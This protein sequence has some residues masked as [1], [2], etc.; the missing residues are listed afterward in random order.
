MQVSLFAFYRYDKIKSNVAF[1]D[2]RDYVGISQD[3]NEV[4]FGA[5]S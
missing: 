5:G 3:I 4:G 2:I 1:F